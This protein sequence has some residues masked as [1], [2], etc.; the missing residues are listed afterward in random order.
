[1]AWFNSDFTI[2]SQLDKFFLSRDLS[3]FVEN[4]DITPCCLSDHDFVNLSFVLHAHASRG[5]GIW[6]INNSL[7]EDESFRLFITERICDLVLCK[8]CYADP[9]SWWDFLKKSLKQEIIS[10]AREKNTRLHRERVFLTNRL[11]ALKRRLTMPAKILSPQ[12]LHHVSHNFLRIF[13][14]LWREQK[15]EAVFNG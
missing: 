2:G 11:I 3:Q 12:K 1:M 6:K 4:A 13:L 10:F 9:A 7:L 8:V 15:L 14:D 5:P